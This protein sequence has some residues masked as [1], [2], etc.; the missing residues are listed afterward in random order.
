MYSAP[1][2]RAAR[3]RPSLRNRLVGFAFVA[4]ATAVTGVAI[5]PPAQAAVGVWDRVAAC[6]SGGN[7][8]VNTGNGYYGGLQFSQ[9]TWRGVGGLRYAPTASRASKAVQIAMARRVL[10]LQGPGAWPICG[11]RAGLTQANGGAAVTVSRARARVAI[12]VDLVVDGKMGP[13]TVRL[14]QR[15]VG[16]RQNGSFGPTTVRALQ[17]KVGVRPNGVLTA[18]TIRALQVKVNA[19]RDGAR[20]LHPSTIRALQRYL[21]RHY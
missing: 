19:R 1:K 4:S 18:R 6:E 14:M 15:W 17:R 2:H 13:K 9:S 8:A 10:A 12:S 20:R 16:T 21:N 5:T 3:K 7:W 11:R